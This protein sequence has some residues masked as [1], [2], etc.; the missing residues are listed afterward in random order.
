MK[1]SNKQVVILSSI[2]GAVAL[3]VAAFITGIFSK[4]K[5]D[6]TQSITTNPKVDTGNLYNIPIQLEQ[7]IAAKLKSILTMLQEI[8]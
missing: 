2:I 6:A 8:K 4:T 7:K 3:I 1:L 5:T